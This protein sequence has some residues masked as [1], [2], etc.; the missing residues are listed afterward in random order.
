[1]RR[2]II[3]LIL[4]VLMCG[5]AFTIYSAYNNHAEVIDL[6]D[7]SSKERRIEDGRFTGKFKPSSDTKKI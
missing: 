1:M 3:F 2:A 7:L 5:I 6:I 4:L